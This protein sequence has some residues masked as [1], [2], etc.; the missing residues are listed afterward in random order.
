MH[1]CSI[2][3]LMFKDLKLRYKP[4]LITDWYSTYFNTW[5]FGPGWLQSRHARFPCTGPCMVWYIWPGMGPIRWFSSRLIVLQMSWPC[6]YPFHQG[7]LIQVFLFSTKCLENA[8]IYVTRTH[9]ETKRWSIDENNTG[10]FSV[11]LLLT[12]FLSSRQ[13]V[14]NFPTYTKLV[15]V[16]SKDHNAKHKNHFNRTGCW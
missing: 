7:R 8:V 1:V 6:N 16:F 13:V 10:G 3:S 15:I 12:F 9:K 11:L 2:P 14:R 5:L 4:G